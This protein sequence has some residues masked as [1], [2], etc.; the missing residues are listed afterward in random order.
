MFL[1]GFKISSINDCEDM[2]ECQMMLGACRNGRCRNTIGSF[3]CICADGYTLTPDGHNCR[4]L[5]ECEEVS[6]S[7]LPLE[8][9]A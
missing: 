4:D 8:A 2:D 7:K 6:P 9:N 1:R 5:N 3:T